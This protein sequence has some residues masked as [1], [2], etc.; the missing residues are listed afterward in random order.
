MNGGKKRVVAI[1]QVFT[2]Y[3]ISFRSIF[4]DSFYRNLANDEEIA[5][6]KRGDFN[7]D[8]PDAFE[9]TLMVQTLRELKRG[10][11][12]KIPTYDY[13]TQS[14]FLAILTFDA[15]ANK[16]VRIGWQQVDAA[17]VILVEGILI[18]FDQELRDIF[19]LKLFVDADP[20][21]RL[22][23]RGFIYDFHK[24]YKA[25]KLSVT[26]PSGADHSSTFCTNI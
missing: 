25:L 2:I 13:R 1:S 5:K 16:I 10:K 18:F 4:K 6:A 15:Y 20:D 21:I 11:G 14:R 8:H 12:V 22:A 19:D 9:H 7:F 23:R 3:L 17:D 26:R 24:I